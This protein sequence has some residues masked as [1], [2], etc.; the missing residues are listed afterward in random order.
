MFNDHEDVK[1]LSDAS[2]RQALKIAE[3]PDD[4]FNEHVGEHTSIRSIIDEFVIFEHDELR[5]TPEGRTRLRELEKERQCQ[6]AEATRRDAEHER[7]RQE[8]AARQREE[9]TR[10]QQER[11]EETADLNVLIAAR[12]DAF[13]EVGITLDRRDRKEMHQIV[14]LLKKPVYEIL[15]QAAFDHRMT[16]QAVLRAGLRTWLVAHGYDVPPDDTGAPVPPHRNKRANHDG[17]PEGRRKGK[18]EFDAYCASLVDERKKRLG[19]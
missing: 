11:Q 6:Q 4:F 1:Q 5:A 15:R 19:W 13:D 12:N 7:W 14:F 3:M 18:A 2:F 9:A 8:E 17:T 16:M 10:Q